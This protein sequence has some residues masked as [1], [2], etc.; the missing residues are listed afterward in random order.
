MLNQKQA[1]RLTAEERYNQELAT[2]SKADKDNNKP[3][4]WLLSPKSVR[5][6]ILGNESLGISRKFFGDDPLVDRAIVSLLGKQGLMLVGQPGTAKSMLSELL[7]AA[8]SGDSN[9]I[10]F[11]SSRDSRHQ[12]RSYPLFMELCIIACRRAH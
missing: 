8:I 11:D 5:Q 7:A 2:L 1:I 3:Q 4:G 10:K 12:R 9:L 6:F